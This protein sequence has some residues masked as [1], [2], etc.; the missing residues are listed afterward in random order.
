[1]HWVVGMIVA[2][3][4]VAVVGRFFGER[5]GGLLARG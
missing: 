2:I 5:R 1:M 4:F 3:I